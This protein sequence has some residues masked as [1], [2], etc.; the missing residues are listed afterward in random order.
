MNRILRY[1]STMLLLLLFTA[2]DTYNLLRVC[3][4][5]GRSRN[6]VIS[7]GNC[8]VCVVFRLAIVTQ[9]E[10]MLCPHVRVG[11]RGVLH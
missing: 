8:D 3:M 1:A 5:G 11:G 9:T 10:S 7:S 4:N 6:N 2:E